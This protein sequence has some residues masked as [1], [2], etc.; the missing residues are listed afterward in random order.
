MQADLDVTNSS[1]LLVTSTALAAQTELQ[2]IMVYAD[3]LKVYKYIGETG[4][5]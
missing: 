2:E 1:L 4:A 3:S 5:P